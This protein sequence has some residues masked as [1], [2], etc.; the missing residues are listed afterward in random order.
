MFLWV[1]TLFFPF[2][3]LPGGNF[4]ISSETRHC[5]GVWSGEG[6]DT[7]PTLFI[8]SSVEGSQLFCL[9][10]WIL[11]LL[12]NDPSKEISQTSEIWELV[13]GIHEAHSFQMGRPEEE[14]AEEQRKEGGRMKGRGSL[15]SGSLC[16][17]REPGQP[18]M[19]SAGL[20]S[21]GVP[22][23]K[24]LPQLCT[25]SWDHSSHYWEVSHHEIVSS[26]GGDWLLEH[27]MKES[28]WPGYQE[29]HKHSRWIF[30]PSQKLQKTRR[31]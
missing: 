26:E 21:D 11:L 23:P 16:L 4:N 5:V 27:S 3:P 18:L 12:K 20:P 9:P 13:P 19:C 6:M 8:F 31:F 30:S 17:P 25:T 2:C 14:E 29:G 15:N 24:K 7:Y 1:Q 28:P 10:N 22:G